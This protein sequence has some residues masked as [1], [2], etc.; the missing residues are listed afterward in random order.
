MVCISAL[1]SYIPTYFS[2]L[3]V[4]M[5]DVSTLVEIEMDE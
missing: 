5:K 2:I 4:A 3:L 1:C